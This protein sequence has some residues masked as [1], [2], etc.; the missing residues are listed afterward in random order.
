MYALACYLL[1]VAFFQK[2]LSKPLALA[3]TLEYNTFEHAFR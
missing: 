3:R 1:A 2:N